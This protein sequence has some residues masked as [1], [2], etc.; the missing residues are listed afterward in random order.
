MEQVKKYIQLYTKLLD[1]NG[2]I[3][4]TE[5]ETRASEFLSA[6][7]TLAD[8]KHMFSEQK[9]KA[10][11]LQSAVY[12]EEMSKG[13]FKTMTENKLHVE[14]SSAFVT[15]RENLER[16]ENDISYLKAH[17][18]I[19]LNAHLFYRQMARGQNE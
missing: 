5:A 7:A 3:S 18:D 17:M 15:A 13:E 11:S 4:Y 2:S 19:F 9:I 14:A 16:I 1:L 6:L 8:Y 10:T 12:A